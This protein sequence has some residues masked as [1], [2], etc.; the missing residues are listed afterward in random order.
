MASRRSQLLHTTHRLPRTHRL[1]QL[2]HRRAQLLAAVEHA[3]HLNLAPQRAAPVLEG[4]QH[5]R[6]RI[7]QR[8]EA[9]QLLLRSAGW[10]GC[11]ECVDGRE[12]GPSLLLCVLQLLP[13]AD[14]VPAALPT[15]PAPAHHAALQE[16]VVGHIQLPQV[17][18]LAQLLCLLPQ[19]RD[20]RLPLHGAVMEV[21]QQLVGGGDL[22]AGRRGGQ[23]VGNS[24]RSRPSAR[25][26]SL[27]PSAR[28]HQPDR[29]ACCRAQIPAPPLA[30]LFQ[31]QVAAPGYRKRCLLQEEGA[32]GVDLLA[33]SVALA[34]HVD[35]LG[36]LER[37][38]LLAPAARARATEEG[39]IMLQHW[40][41][42][43]RQAAATETR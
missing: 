5:R 41:W 35:G 6:H 16:D 26:I 34:P 28:F 19:G 9:A 39:Q 23:G 37:R 8:L 42:C 4:V 40:R 29:S 2:L 12:C 11:V 7:P 21:V 14:R 30:H 27:L 10:G 1:G 18:L 3:L 24:S 32:V 22:W 43:G 15:C 38:K 20:R 13:T 33:E 25:Q 17:L 31:G 36:R